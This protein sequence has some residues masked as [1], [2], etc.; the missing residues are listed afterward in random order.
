MTGFVDGSDVSWTIC[1]QSAPHPRQITTPTPHHFVRLTTALL[2][3]EESARDDHVVACN[4][5][6]YSPI[7]KLYCTTQQ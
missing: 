3:D 1:K 4:F 7:K 5:A 6:K 2:K